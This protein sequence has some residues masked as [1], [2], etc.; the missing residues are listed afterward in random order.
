VI[1]NMHGRTTIKTLLFIS[2]PI[3]SFD[4]F[5]FH[6]RPLRLALFYS[7]LPRINF[8]VLSSFMLIYTYSLFFLVL[9]SAL[10][11]LATHTAQHK[12]QLQCTPSLCLA[13]SNQSITEEGYTTFIGVG[14]RRSEDKSEGN[15]MVLKETDPYTFNTERRFSE[16]FVNAPRWVILWK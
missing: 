3:L 11:N 8:L 16:P 13:I 12:L 7:N 9:S 6:F 10:S 4:L 1:V 2:F 14:G 15:D 5:P